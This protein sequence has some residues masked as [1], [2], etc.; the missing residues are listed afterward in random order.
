M[1]ATSKE[2]LYTIEE[3]R[4]IGI[5]DKILTKYPIGVLVRDDYKVYSHLDMPQQS[6]WVHLLRVS[7][8][9]ESKEAKKLHRELKKMFKSLSNIV[10]KEFNDKKRKKQYYRYSKKI[11]NIIN[12]K[13]FKKDT[14]KIQNRI[15]NQ[16]TNLITALLYPNIPLTNNHAEQQIRPLTVQRK[17]SGGSRSNEGARTQAVNMSIIQ[18]L[19]LR[20]EN[21]YLGLSNLLASTGQEFVVEKGE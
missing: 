4:G 13:Y 10:N 20:G 16:N 5:S 18:T 3:T 8:D 6:C 17:I 1:F 15:K 12:R 19:K 21:L 7:R 9:G 14:L 2:A 11:Q